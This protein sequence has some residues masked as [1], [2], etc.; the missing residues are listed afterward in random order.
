[1][2]PF[3]RLEIRHIQHHD[4]VA[5]V[6]NSQDRSCMVLLALPL[7]LLQKAEIVVRGKDS[8]ADEGC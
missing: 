8:D 6:S 7:R 5:P 2:I 4:E 1:M 3:A